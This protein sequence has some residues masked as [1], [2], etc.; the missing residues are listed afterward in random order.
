MR[1]EKCFVV[2]AGWW[3][4]REHRARALAG[5][6]DDGSSGGAGG[7]DDD[8]HHRHGGASGGAGAPSAEDGDGPEAAR[9]AR[10]AGARARGGAR[11][12]KGG[13]LSS[14]DEQQRVMLSQ[15]INDDDR[16]V[17]SG[18]D[19]AAA[20]ADADGPGGEEEALPPQLDIWCV[21]SAAAT[22]SFI[23][24]LPVTLITSLVQKPSGDTVASFARGA[25]N[26]L[27]NNS[28]GGGGDHDDGADDDDGGDAICSAAWQWCVAPRSFVGLAR[29][30]ARVISREPRVEL[31]ASRAR[32][33]RGARM[34][35]APRCALDAV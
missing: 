26:C 8:H 2:Y 14:G 29:G 33:T 13:G 35:R 6:D 4:R 21:N 30:R 23:W 11:P 25:L 12:L 34:T 17:G 18:G 19:V 15:S 5:D 1:K 32:V 28:G 20:D 10:E 27:T 16:A 9:P 7:S 3:R 22:W 24:V 31:R